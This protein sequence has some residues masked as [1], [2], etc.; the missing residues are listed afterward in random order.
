M[1]PSS[2]DAIVNLRESVQALTF[3]DLRQKLPLEGYEE[4]IEKAI[5]DNLFPVPADALEGTRLAVQS[6]PR[7]SVDSKGKFTEVSRKMGRKGNSQSPG[8]ET[9]KPAIT[10]TTKRFGS[11]TNKPTPRQKRASRRLSYYEVE[12]NGYI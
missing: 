6:A 9:K 1:G 7:K 3:A 5:K 2:T 8:V 12:K 4:I 10:P 11:L